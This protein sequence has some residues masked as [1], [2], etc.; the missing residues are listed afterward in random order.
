[1]PSIKCCTV[2]IFSELRVLSLVHCFTFLP[3]INLIGMCCFMVGFF[4]FVLVA[5]FALHV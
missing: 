1:L 2:F 3:F 5:D 4:L